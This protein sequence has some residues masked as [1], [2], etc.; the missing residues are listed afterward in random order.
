[1]KRATLLT[2]IFVLFV[3]G[4]QLKGIKQQ[5]SNIKDAIT[6]NIPSVNTKIRKPY[7]ASVVIGSRDGKKFGSGVIVYNKAGHSISVLTAAHIVKELKKHGNGIYFVSSFEEKIYEAYV[8]RSNK[9]LDLAILHTKEKAV[10]DGPYISLAKVPPSIGDN[11]WVISSILGESHIVTNGIISDFNLY[12]GVM[13]YRTTAE[14]LYGSSGG[15]MFNERGKLVGVARMVRY[16]TLG[17][18]SVQLAPA[19]FFFVGLDSITKFLS[20]KKVKKDGRK[21]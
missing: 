19:G 13:L 2:L 8:Y 9:L 21:I 18:F 11:V 15:G 4:C 17:M 10:E 5:D 6:Y 16:T 14:I 3:C 7:L 20:Q 1:M 12:D